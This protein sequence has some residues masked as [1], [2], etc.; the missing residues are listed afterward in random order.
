MAR[1]LGMPARFRR[2]RHGSVTVMFAAALALCFL[3]VG[4]VFDFWRRMRAYTALQGVGDAT[5]LVAKR[6]EQNVI[7]TKG[8]AY[9]AQA[10][11]DAEAQATR[12]FRETIKT[13]L[14]FFGT[15]PVADPTYAWDNVSGDVKVTSSGTVPSMFTGALFPTRF[16]NVTTVSGAE[17]NVSIDTEIAL[18][19]DNTTSMFF[20][21][22]RASTRFTLLR[23]ATLSF[24]NNIFDAAQLS[25]NPDSVRV[26]VVPWATT[27]NVLGEAPAAQDFSAF[28]MATPADKGSQIEVATPLSRL[29]QVNVTA[30]DFAPVGWRG[31]VSGSV[32]SKTNYTDS[33]VTG[34]NAVR[35]PSNSLSSLSYR[36]KT[37]SNGSCSGSYST[38]SYCPALHNA[39][40]RSQIYLGSDLSCIN[41]TSAPSCMTSSQLASYTSTVQRCVADYNEPAIQDGTINWC[42]WIARDDWR[43][44][45]DA[46][47]PAPTIA[48]PNE[49]CPAPML[50]LSGNRR[51]VVQAVNRMFP[52]PHGTHNDVG[53]RWGLRTLSPSNGW[54]AFF[55]LTKAPKAFGTAAEKVIVL[56]TDGENQ[57][58]SANGFWDTS[59]TE[60]ALDTMMLGWCTAVRTNY[61]VKIYTVAVNV[62]DV[63]AV[64]L[65][66]SC[67][68]TANPERAFSV[69][70]ANLDEAMKTIGRQMK[71]L[72]LNY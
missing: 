32:E 33:A 54:P 15:N 21:D 63:T 55:G 45:G 13:G 36:I 65:L 12:Y 38:R 44:T 64:N 39:T 26:S 11:A 49:N 66:K 53:L 1:F 50:G 48:G 69:D 68:G 22:G 51:Q 8:I 59:T 7:G 17:L 5:A 29:G 46:T 62:S 58:P 71:S 27:V 10:R 37:S 18:V 16:Q 30:A 40:T 4:G 57:T 3:V 19:L 67:V 41:S 60:S 20:Y 23:N 9:Q 6:V 72:K 43:S 47:V 52:V 25:N 61:N 56:I 2:S 70:A 35:V 31:C 28:A 34:W 24:V 42:N 14:R